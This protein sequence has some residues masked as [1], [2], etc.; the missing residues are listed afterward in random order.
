MKKGYFYT[1]DA[2]IGVIILFIGL[3]FAAGYYFYS[4]ESTR[5]EAI[6]NDITG[7]LS[8][9]KIGQLCDLYPDCDCGS[10]NNLENACS[11]LKLSDD[12]MTLM[13]LFGLLY[14]MNRRSYIEGIIQETIVDTN[15]LPQT[16]D[17]QLVLND[18]GHGN[19]QLYPLVEI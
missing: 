5:T 6:T 15:I 18:P 14:H 13:E 10:Y 16:H 12:D 17:I 19:Q 7:L 8:D 4:P 11:E 1:L 3:F 2:L 9:A